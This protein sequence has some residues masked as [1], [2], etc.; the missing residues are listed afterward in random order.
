MLTSRQP[1]QELGDEFFDQR[2]KASKINYL[3]R[4]LEK[5]TGG[6]VHIELQVA[7]A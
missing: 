1:Y 2:K 4:Q 3:T 6:S 7:A 5:L